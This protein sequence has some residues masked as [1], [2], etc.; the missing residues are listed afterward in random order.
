MPPSS[1][2]SDPGLS[3][4]VSSLRHLLCFMVKDFPVG[5]GRPLEEAGCGSVSMSKLSRRWRKEQGSKLGLNL[6][7]H[8][9][10]L[11]IFILTGLLLGVF[12]LGL[13]FHGF[14]FCWP[15]VR[16]HND[17]EDRRHERGMI[18]LMGS[19]S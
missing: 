8:Q 6:T 13:Y 14:L 18:R 19:L 3:L 4:G 15:L 9:S 2:R 16:R 12:A 7:S 11:G 5:F 10:L 1:R 17:D